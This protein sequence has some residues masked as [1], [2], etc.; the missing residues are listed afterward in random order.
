MERYQ[1]KYLINDALESRTN[2]DTDMEKKAIKDILKDVDDITIDQM[3][4]KPTP[5]ET[6][7]VFTRPNIKRSESKPLKERGCECLMF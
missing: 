6:G 1:T 5:L 3:K 4:I 7:L 2:Q